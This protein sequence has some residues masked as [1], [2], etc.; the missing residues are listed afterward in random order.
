M[1]VYTALSVF[2]ASG[3]VRVEKMKQLGSE[4]QIKKKI[5]LKKKI[6]RIRLP[7]LKD[8]TTSQNLQ[9]EKGAQKGEREGETG[10]RER[11]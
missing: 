11:D 6:I 4:K 9:T 5:K 1:S 2:P 8:L 3:Q 10:W 7:G